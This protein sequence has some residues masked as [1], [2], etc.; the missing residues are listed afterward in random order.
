MRDNTDTAKANA[1]L[2]T[3]ARPTPVGKAVEDQHQKKLT[4]YAGLMMLIKKQMMDGKRNTATEFH[5]AVCSTLGEFCS[6]MWK[7][8][9]E[10]VKMY[11]GKLQREGPR[12]DGYLIPELTGKFRTS[13]KTAIQIAVAKGIINT[14][15]NFLMVD[16]L[17]AACRPS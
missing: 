2:P 16:M 8:Q 11:A 12:L 1:G 17:L 14:G 3:E 7:I 5:P 9:E 4:D 10:I 13:F 15:N 6:G